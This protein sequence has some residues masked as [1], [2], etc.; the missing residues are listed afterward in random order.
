M[1]SYE[2]ILSRMKNKYKELSMAE[3]PE[4]SDIDIRMKILAGEIYNDEVN[5][6]FLKRQ[7]FPM[8]ATGEYLDY[9]ADDRGLKRKPAVKATGEVRFFTDDYAQQSI[10]IPKGTIVSTGGINPIRFL[11]DEEKTL[12][13]GNYYVTV[14]C[15]AEKGGIDGNVTPNKIDTMVTNVVG[16]DSVNNLWSFNGGSDA[17]SDDAL[18]NRVLNSY[19]YLSNGTNKSYYK[20]LA[21]SVDGVYSVNVVPKARGVGTVDVYISSQKAGASHELQN[22]VQA[23]M[24][25][26]REV[27]VDVLVDT[28]VVD[29]YNLGVYVT[30]KD[31]YDLEDVKNN[32]IE[33][34]DEYISTLEVGDSI[35][36]ISLT[37]AICQAEGVY[38]FSFN[39]MFPG[40]HWADVDTLIVLGDTYIEESEEEEE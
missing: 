21:L 15:I 23:V 18:R 2:D 11:T 28:A 30:L 39:S 31:G 5:L 17:E 16:I 25:R 3:V 36:E 37:N 20:R 24:T 27:N 12:Q 32:I 22:K 14:K 38:N 29:H 35:L 33:K 19:A 9:H 8:T 34:V 13:Q 26:E 6:E 10:V 7:I 4:L 40:Y 1:D